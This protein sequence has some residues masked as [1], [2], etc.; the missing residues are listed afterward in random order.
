MCEDCGR[1]PGKRP[2]GHFNLPV[3]KLLKNTT[4]R[5]K[6]KRERGRCLWGVCQQA[7]GHDR[8]TEGGW[9]VCSSFLGLTGLDWTELWWV[10]ECATP[11]SAGGNRKGRWHRLG[12]WEPPPDSVSKSEQQQQLH[13]THK[14]R[15]CAAAGD[16]VHSSCSARAPPGLLHDVDV[17][18]SLLF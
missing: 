13:H 15:G 1:L 10:P 12:R 2:G 8:D 16:S 7:D 14:A 17:V 4:R 5:K 3:H 9:D 11:P 18:I 6:I